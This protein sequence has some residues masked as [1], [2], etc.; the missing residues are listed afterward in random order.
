MSQQSSRNWQD[1]RRQSVSRPAPRPSTPTGGSNQ[2]SSNFQDR[3]TQSIA[4]VRPGLAKNSSS[5][6]NKF[7]SVAKKVGSAIKKFASGNLPRDTSG[8]QVYT[9]PKTGETTPIQAG[10]GAP[11]IV[12]P[13]GKAAKVAKAAADS[14]SKIVP[15]AAKK[16]GLMQRSINKVKSNGLVNVNLHKHFY[17]APVLGETSVNPKTVG[18]VN[19]IISNRFSVAAIGFGGAWASSVM[20]GKWGQAESAEPFKFVID[21]LSEMAQETG[22]WSLVNEARVSRQELLDSKTWEDIALWSPISAFVGVPKKIKGVLEAATYHDKALDYLEEQSV[23]GESDDEMW[24]RIF[25][26]RDAKRVQDRLDDEAYYNRIAEQRAEAEAAKRAEDAKYW[27]DILA[28]RDA[29]ALAKREA[30]EKYWSNV[31]KNIEESKRKESVVP[32][33]SSYEPPSNLKFGLI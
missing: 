13:A 26:E 33:D 18:L 25:A 14:A 2:S 8:Q 15:S 22:D 20:L 23:S 10:L 31:F 27:A 28:K 21:D 24:Q 32:G 3:Q 30:D 7:V 29:D 17:K 16:A 1:R 9:D 11:E 19:K 6:Q 12:L 4:P 5:K